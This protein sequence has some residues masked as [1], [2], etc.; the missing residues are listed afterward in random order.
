M[1][2]A[3]NR[4]YNDPNV[5][6]AFS[7]LAAAFMPP[8][9]SDLAG[10]ATA[11]AKKEEAQRLAQL[12]T[13]AQAT[14]G[15]NQQVFDRMGQATGQWTPSTGYY[16]VDSTAATSRANNAADNER[17][18]QTNAADNAGALARLY[19]APINVTEGSTTYLP[20][21]TQAATGLAPTL[22]G[23][24]TLAPGEQTYLPGGGLITGPTKPL[25]ETEVMGAI[26]QGLPATDQRN[27]VMGDVPVEQIIMDGQPTIVARPDAVGQTPYDKPTGSPET[28]NYK[29]PDGKVGTAVYDPTSRTWI[30]TATQQPVPQGSI[31]FN[32][33]LEGGAAETGLAPTTAN[34]TA[35]NTIEATLNAMDADADAM[36]GLLQANPGIAGLPGAIFGTAQNAASVLGEMSAAFGDMAPDAAITAEQ[37]QAAIQRVMPTR[38][39][40][41]QKFNI[42]IANLAYRLAQMNNPT[43][44]VSRQAYERSLESLQGGFLANNQ[45]ALE[46]LT[47]LK[48]QVARNRETQLQTLRNPGQGGAPAAPA[49]ELPVV[50]SPE[51]A[52]ALPSGTQFKDPQGNIRTVP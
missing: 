45:S 32:S 20:Q 52:A 8:S 31:T 36:I 42:G 23:N 34:L 24:I 6:A 47:A 38:N 40:A 48:E 17:A 29:A 19:A 46:A 7:N 26:L 25:S 44:E 27:K 5:G 21:Q 18:I 10:Y 16:G 39:E 30:D 2:V 37:A 49:A 12:F 50:N 33:S 11:A 1:A 51:E 35:A 14:D 28:Q 9:G 13:T 4:Y 3:S 43:G 15:F 22:A 41:I